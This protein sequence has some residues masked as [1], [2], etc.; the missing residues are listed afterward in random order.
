VSIFYTIV[1]V[2]DLT[3]LGEHIDNIITS[4]AY[5]VEVGVPTIRFVQKH[6][7]T[8]LLN[9]STATTFFFSCYC[10]EWVF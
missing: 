1:R 3:L 6:G 8:N 9:L 4:L 5:F 10:L 2:T 7:T